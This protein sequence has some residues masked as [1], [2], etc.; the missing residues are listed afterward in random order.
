MGTAVDAQRNAFLGFAACKAG[1]NFLTM[2]RNYGDRTK[3]IAYSQSWKFGQQLLSRKEGKLFYQICED[4][5]LDFIR[6]G[7][8][9][10][11]TRKGLGFGRAKW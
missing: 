8:S 10:T 7:S 9:A 11:Q 1:H 4:N 5:N 2:V 3:A 6:E